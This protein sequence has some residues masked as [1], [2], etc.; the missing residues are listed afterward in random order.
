[1]KRYIHSSTTE[2]PVTETIR[3]VVDVDFSLIKE[4][5]A[6]RRGVKLPTG[7]LLPAEKD[8][9]ID[10]QVLADYHAF[11]ETVRDLI[12]DYYNL[13]IYYKNSSDDNSFYFGFLA[14]N[15]DGSFLLDFEATIRISNHDPH[16]TPQADHAKKEQNEEL[17]K[18]TDGVR[19]RP[20]R[21]NIIVNDREF[22]SYEEAY[23]QVDSI[24]QRAVQVLEK[25]KH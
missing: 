5:A 18:L 11:I 19:P 17:M 20:W 12:A 16:G 14:K 15:S 1:M 24:V 9:L 21:K 8:A 10:S 13:H 25:K 2:E 22:S 23:D 7:K 4:V 3:I 6:S